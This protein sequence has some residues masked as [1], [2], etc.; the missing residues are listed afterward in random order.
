M[1]CQGEGTAYTFKLLDEQ[2]AITL[3]S[4][5][6]CVLDCSRKLHYEHFEVLLCY[7]CEGCKVH[8]LARNI[9]IHFKR[10]FQNHPQISR[11]TGPL[12]SSQLLRPSLPALIPLGLR[13][14]PNQA[15]RANFVAYPKQLRNIDIQRAV[16]LRA[17]EQLMYR[18]HSC[19][20]CER[21]CPGGLQGVETDLAG[22]EVDIWVADGCYEADC[23]W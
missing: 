13:V 5:P 11:V 14:K 19:C 17:R 8:A 18:G 4:F 6:S 7:T 23:G 15:L 20:Y 1:A 16:R 21:G 12:R 2:A 10:P 9:G 22:L 3:L